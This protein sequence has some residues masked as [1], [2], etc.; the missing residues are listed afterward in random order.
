MNM[1]FNNKVLDFL[2]KIGYGYY[3]EVDNKI[4]LP[5]ELG[6]IMT[7]VEEVIVKI[8]PNISKLVISTINLQNG[9]ASVPS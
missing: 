3:P 7:T 4:F 1:S 8:Y 2:F 6:T 5:A 9:C